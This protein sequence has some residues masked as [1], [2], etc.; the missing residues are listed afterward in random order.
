MTK[1]K[2]KNIVEASIVMPAVSAEE[3]VRAW[4]GYQDLKKKIIDKNTDIQIIGKE[5]FLKKSYWRKLATFFNL[6]VKVVKE[7]KDTT[8]TTFDKDG[9]KVGN[10]VYNFTCMAKAPNGR[11]AVGTGSCEMY[12]KGY[13]NSIHNVRATAETRAFNRAVSNLVGGG[14][15]SAEEVDQG[16]GGSSDRLASDAQK[17][18]IFKLASNAGLKPAETKKFTKKK[19][20]LDS[21]T[22]LTA[23]QAS[24]VIES[25]QEKTNTH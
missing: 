6:T 2:E 13:R 17:K 20:K 4:E 3:A 11:S 19:F 1:K 23:S 9:K 18:F 16:S 25:L 24:E 21:F 7:E 14:E 22:E 10:L 15:V 5:E 8:M 12:E